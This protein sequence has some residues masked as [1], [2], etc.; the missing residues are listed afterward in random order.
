[1]M[2][3]G[4]ENPDHP[5]SSDPGIGGLH[6]TWCPA[7]AMTV[8]EEIAWR[9]SLVETQSEPDW[10]TMDAAE[11]VR[12]LQ[13]MGFIRRGESHQPD[14]P[15]QFDRGLRCNCVPDSDHY[16]VPPDVQALWGQ[17]YEERLAKARARSGRDH[18]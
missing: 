4:C 9:R 7:Y 16:M 18:G 13:A 15:A 12:I 6:Y 5:G 14:C 11:K 10:A 3:C 8:D 17:T 1:M 2:K